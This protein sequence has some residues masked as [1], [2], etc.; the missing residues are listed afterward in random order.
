MS[1]LK[2]MRVVTLEQVIE[3]RAQALNRI[4]ALEAQNAAMRE[5]L[6]GVYDD[7]SEG[8][9]ISPGNFIK[10]GRALQGVRE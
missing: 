8:L 9:F 3:F 6:Q 4:K 7:Y 10:V 5:A 2:D 1:E